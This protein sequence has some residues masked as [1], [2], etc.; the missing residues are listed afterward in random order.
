MAI[1]LTDTLFRDSELVCQSPCHS[2]VQWQP[3][4]T[5][6]PFMSQ[7]LCVSYPTALSCQCEALHQEWRLLG[8]GQEEQVK[9]A[10]SIPATDLLVKRVRYLIPM[11]PRRLTFKTDPNSR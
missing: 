8:K 7:Y 10:E 2:S 3:T 1:S 11:G 4:R 5:T 6:A 9:K